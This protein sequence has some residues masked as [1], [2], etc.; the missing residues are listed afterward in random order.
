MSKNITA[1]EIVFDYN[2]I[3]S[4]QVI[5]TTIYF[6]FKHFLQVE[7]GAYLQNMPLKNGFCLSLPHLDVLTF[8]VQNNALCV[9][10]EINLQK[11]KS[12][13]KLKS[14]RF[15][16]NWYYLSSAFFQKQPLNSHLL[17]TLDMNQ[18][19]NKYHPESD[20]MFHVKTIVLM[21]E[22]CLSN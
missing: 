20:I 3:K 22:L 9:Q 6:L 12:F 4:S 13:S 18:P 21:F 11:G 2:T 19:N 5:C 16:W 8:T 14:G 15:S 17:N 10:S 7:E 1:S